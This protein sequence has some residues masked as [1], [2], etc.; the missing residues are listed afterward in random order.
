MKHVIKYSLILYLIFITFHCFGQKKQQESRQLKKANTLFQKK[1]YVKA[2]EEY[3][4]MYEKDRANTA[5]NYHIGICLYHQKDKQL[6]A[7]PYFE[8]SNVQQFPEVLFYKGNLY[9]LLL[10]FNEAIDSFTAY[11]KISTRV[12]DSRFVSMLITKSLTAQQMMKTSL[13]AVIK[14]MGNTIN[15]SY[16]DYVPLLSAEGS[17]LIFTSRRANSTG[18]QKDLNGEYMEDIYTSNKNGNEWTTPISISKNI[19]TEL[20]DA[21]VALS[22]DGQQLI[23]Y[24]TSDDLRSGDLYISNFTGSDWTKPERM[25]SDINMDDAIEASATFSPDNNTLIFSSDRPGGL[26]GRD[27]YKVVKLPNGEWSKAMSLGNTINTSYDEDAPFLHADGKT[28]Y[29]SSKAHKNMGGY[30]IFKSVFN[31]DN[32]WSE[33]E[34]LGYPIN[35]VYDDIYFILSVNGNRGYFSSNGGVTFG[36]A[37]IFSIDIP[38]QNFDLAVVS[39]KVFGT[40]NFPLKA[41]I[42]LTEI[43]NSVIAE[44]Y[45]S[46]KNTGKFIM[47]LSPIKKYTMNIQAQGYLPLSKELFFSAGDFDDHVM[48]MDIVLKKNNNQ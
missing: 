15:S 21:C 16:P 31:Q 10:R 40:D 33:P 28:L 12:N 8:K 27:L 43:G 25:G 7:L 22:Q 23:V 2:G 1:E 36:G 17:T 39:C 32:T 38:E 35:T 20:H 48:K 47:I 34:N 6:Q 37:D 3:L 4:K 14:N 30:D 29:F 11:N 9:H 19:N 13:N 44:E 26:G 24:Q 46:N 5:L 41:S 45:K 42:T 18:M